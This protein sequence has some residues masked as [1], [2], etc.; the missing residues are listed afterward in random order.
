MV[1]TM[2]QSEITKDSIKVPPNLHDWASLR[3]SWS[4]SDVRRELDLPGGLVNLAHEAIDR[5]AASQP[6]KVAMIWDGVAQ[7]LQ[8]SA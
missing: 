8:A 4:W 1:V 7:V 2:E 3:Q 6:D 5:H